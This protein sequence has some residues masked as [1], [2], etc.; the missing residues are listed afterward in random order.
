[1]N[2]LECAKE[3]VSRLAVALCHSCCAALCLDHAE[4]VPQRLE[5][6]V[7][8]CGT[9]TLPI[10]AR[11]VLCHTCREAIQQPRELRTA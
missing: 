3:G 6:R 8:V 5:M 7:P 11:Q 1:M 9:A 4:I 10:A 2:C